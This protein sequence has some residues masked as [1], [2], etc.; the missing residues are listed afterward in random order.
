MFFSRIAIKYFD[1]LFYSSKGLV[2]VIL[3]NF[4]ALITGSDARATS[5]NNS[6]NYLVRSIIE[7]D[8][9]IIKFSNE[10]VGANLYSRGIKER[11]EGIGKA[12]CLQRINFNHG[13]CII[14]CGAN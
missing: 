7:S 5:I 9:R 13:D 10:S 1:Y 6:A 4:R 2:F 3:F 8:K 11:G 12:Y 14:D